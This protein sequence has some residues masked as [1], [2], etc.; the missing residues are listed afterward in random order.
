M[1]LAEHFH[2]I[3]GEGYWVGT[4]MHFIRTAGCS[5]GRLLSANPQLS[6]GARA[7]TCKAFDGQTFLC[8]TDFNRYCEM[9]VDQL[10][11]DTY[12]KHVCLT[13]GE[14]LM[15]HNHPE[16]IELCAQLGELRRRLHIETSGTE[17]IPLPV[18]VNSW[19]TVAP[20]VG[21]LPGVLYAADEV[22]LLVNS[23]TTED[24]ISE[25]ISKLGPDSLVFLSPINGEKEI[26]DA[27]LQRALELL[28]KFPQRLQL[29]VQLHKYLGVR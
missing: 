28:K 5:V 6:T 18:A 3:Q 25:I 4:P 2:S 1:K 15:K 26:S 27:S 13:G 10:V 8:D 24:T 22:K 21:Y 20:K 16:I 9:S 23:S 7:W 17:C 14:P 11:A 12:E 19:I 29:S